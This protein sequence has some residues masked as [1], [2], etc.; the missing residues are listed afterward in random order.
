MGFNDGIVG[1]EINSYAVWLNWE[2]WGKKGVLMNV[3]LEE[4]ISLLCGWVGS[5]GGETAAI[6][7]RAGFVAGLLKGLSSG[8]YPRDIK[9]ERGARG[10]EFYIPGPAIWPPLRDRLVPGEEVWRALAGFGS[11][12]SDPHPQTLVCQQSVSAN[13]SQKRSTAQSPAAAK[14][15][16]KP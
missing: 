6:L 13:S 3:L 10:W 5:S 2:F 11:T 15:R 16:L 4:L 9:R 7:F 8:G 14:K 1:G 12:P